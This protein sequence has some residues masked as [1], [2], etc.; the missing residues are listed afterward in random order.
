M[1]QKR[2]YAS[3]TLAGSVTSLI[4][5]IHLEVFLFCTVTLIH[6]IIIYEINSMRV[7]SFLG[8]VQERLLLKGHSSIIRKNKNIRTDSKPNITLISK[9]GLSNNL[10]SLDL[11]DKK[12]I[13]AVIS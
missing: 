12:R 3:E 9:L 8:W 11:L 2:L 13:L 7:E 5:S 6:R 10:D 4:R 1:V